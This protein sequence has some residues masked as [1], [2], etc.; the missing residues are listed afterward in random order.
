M[1]AFKWLPF[2]LKSPL[3]IRFPHVIML[4]TGVCRITPTQG[5]IN[6]TLKQW[7]QKIFEHIIRTKF[8]SFDII[9]SRESL[10]F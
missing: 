7:P 4:E 5:Q 10:F 8:W 6:C 9:T 3:E 1:W 2:M